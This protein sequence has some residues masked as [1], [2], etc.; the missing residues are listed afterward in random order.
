MIGPSVPDSQNLFTD[1][2]IQSGGVVGDKKVYN[3]QGEFNGRAV[4]VK[5]STKED[6]NDDDIA[7]ILS[8]SFVSN[9]KTD[10]NT[11]KATLKNKSL[12]GTK[13]TLEHKGDDKVDEGVSGALLAAKNTKTSLNG[14]LK[15]DTATRQALNTLK[16]TFSSL[17]NHV[18]SAA[19][20]LTEN[21]GKVYSETKE[22]LFLQ[23]D[24]ATDRFNETVGRQI[25]EVMYGKGQKVAPWRTQPGWRTSTPKDDKPNVAQ[26]L[27]TWVTNQKGKISEQIRKNTEWISVPRINIFNEKTKTERSDSVAKPNWF[28]EQKTKVKEWVAEQKERLSPKQETSEKQTRRL[29]EQ[30]TKGKEKVAEQK[31]HP[32]PKVSSETKVETQE[33]Y[34][35]FHNQQLNLVLD[36]FNKR[37]D[38]R[39]TLALTSEGLKVAPWG[40]S[41]A[42]DKAALKHILF[43]IKQEVHNLISDYND[44]PS[45]S[46]DRKPILDN[47]AHIKYMFMNMAMRDDTPF[48]KILENDG[49]LADEFTKI[50]RDISYNVNKENEII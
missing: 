28:S 45:D 42:P 20:R 10:D 31:E 36:Y 49:Q 33:K 14:A 29:S 26:K 4:T 41:E 37:D 47:L 43:L 44:L 35:S 40:P 23:A 11:T 19:T 39:K 1:L 24:I 50:R 2:K 21:A 6:L 13:I 8:E 18:D 32:S 38:S 22:N 17:S 30:K 25:R 46:P 48:K 5:I 12:T 34:S 27:E 7:K 15:T 9:V 3:V 16:D